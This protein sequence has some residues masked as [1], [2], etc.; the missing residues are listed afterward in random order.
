MDHW[1]GQL[2]LR[3]EEGYSGAETELRTAFASEAEKILVEMAT[4]AE[5]QHNEHLRALI[6]TLQAEKSR[7]L[8]AAA[9]EVRACVCDLWVGCVLL[10]SLGVL[11]PAFPSLLLNAHG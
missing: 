10:P 2:R 5:L 7:K 1:V 11:A 8:A 9:Q 4:I 3:L 6:T